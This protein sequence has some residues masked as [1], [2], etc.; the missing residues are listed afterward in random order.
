LQNPDTWI[1]STFSVLACGE[2]SSKR[3]SRTTKD[4]TILKRTEPAFIEPM[5]CKPITALPADEKW[6][7]EIKFDGY[8]CIALKRGREVTLFSRNQKVLNK[9]FP[10]VVEALASLARGRLRSRWGTSGLG[11]AR[12]TFLSASTEQPVSGGT[13]LFL[14]LRSAKPKWGAAGRLAD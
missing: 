12:E 9:R 7:F 13:G 10:K 2:I 4:E 6:T 3:G 11:S 8:R 5:Q 1:N 14:R